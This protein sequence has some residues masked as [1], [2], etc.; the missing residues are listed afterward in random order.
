MPRVERSIFGF[1]R[2]LTSE[3]ADG[4]HR[5]KHPNR[6]RAELLLIRLTYEAPLFYS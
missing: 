1:C 4:D 6:Q 2:A 3:G 5:S